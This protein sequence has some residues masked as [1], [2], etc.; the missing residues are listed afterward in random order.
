MLNFDI[1]INLG[2]QTYVYIYIMST[3]SPE[4]ISCSMLIKN[5]NSNNFANVVLTYKAFCI[6]VYMQYE[7]WIETKDYNIHIR[8]T[9][10]RL[11]P[12]IMYI[13]YPK[14]IPNQFTFQKLV[15]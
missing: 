7:I 13:L 4:H 2:L 14:G 1:Y 9:F 8:Y 10:H 6:C 3:Y 11:I 15:Y 12:R 5:I